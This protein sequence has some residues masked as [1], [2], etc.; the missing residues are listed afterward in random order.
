MEYFCND[1]K[2][3][4]LFTMKKLNY[5]FSLLLFTLVGGLTAWGQDDGKMY[6]AV[7]QINP[8]DGLEEG[9]D[10]VLRGTG[11]GNCSSNYLDLTADGNAGSTEILTS[12]IW[13][14]VKAGELDS[15][16]TYY[17]RNKTT[18]QY[19]RKP[20]ETLDLTYNYM[21]DN[22]PAGWGDK[23]LALTDDVAQAFL[24]WA[25]RGD[26]AVSASAG[27]RF[28]SMYAYPENPDCFIFCGVE[29]WNTLTEA[30]ENNVRWLESYA[31]NNCIANYWDVNAWY[32]Y[33][34]LQEITG[35]DK[36][37]R[38]LQQLLPQGPEGAF[39]AG[40][41]PGNVEVSAYNALTDV[42]ARVLEYMEVPTTDEE[43]EQLA[44]EIRAA[45]ENCRNS[46]IL[47]E[48]GKYYFV[49]NRARNNA[50]GRGT[51]YCN[52]GSEWNWEYV[53][54]EGR[55][56]NFSKYAVQLVAGETEGMFLVK[57]PLYNKYMEAI[58]GNSNTIMAVDSIE[59][60]EYEIGHNS[61]TYFFFRNPGI[62]QGVHA[63]E[64]GL[65]CVGWD[66]TTEASQWIFTQISD[67]KVQAIEDAARQAQLNVA[68]NNVYTTASS[69]YVS[70]R[71]YTSDATLDEAYESHGLL[72]STDQI[73][74]SPLAAGDGTGISCLLNGVTRGGSEYMHTTWNSG[75]APNHYHF[76]GAD[77]KK[78]VGAIT[79]KFSNRYDGY[80]RNSYPTQ[81]R[82]YA[83]N[84]TTTATG[85]WTWV[86]E[87]TTQLVSDTA[88]NAWVA[89]T[90]F[91]GTNYRYVRLD[92]TATGDN[93]S[94][95]PSGGQAFPYFY[96]SELGIYEAAYD[97]ANSPFESVPEEDGQALADALQKAR[98]EILSE[99]ATQTTVD[100]LQAAYD[101]F[102]ESY[103]D[104]QIAR[105]AIAEAQ[106]MLDSAVVGTKLA[107]VTQEA[108]DAL[109]Q[110]IADATEKVS[111]VMTM[112][113]LNGIVT[114]LEAAREALA[115]S[116]VMPEAGQY[117]WIISKGTGKNNAAIGAASNRDGQRLKFGAV[118]EVEGLPNTFDETTA[119]TYYEYV[120]LLEQDDEGNQYLRNV[121]TGFYMNGNTTANPTTTAEKTPVKVIY[122]KHG[123]FGVQ[124]LMNDS[125]ESGN[126]YLNNNA[127]DVTKYSLDNNSY[128]EFR[129]VDFGPEYYTYVPV[130]G[131]WHFMCLPYATVGSSNGVSYTVLGI[132]SENELVLAEASD[133]VAPGE[134]FV[135]YQEVEE[136]EEPITLDDFG[137]DLTQGLVSEGKTINGIQGILSGYTLSETGYG[138]LNGT[139]T[140]QV[141]TGAVVLGNN[142]AIATKDVIVTD[143][144]GAAVLPINGTLTGIGTG[145]DKVVIVPKDG[146][147][148]DGKIYDL[149]G[150]RVSRPGKGIYIVNGKKM[151]FK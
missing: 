116:A 9:V 120:W 150:R 41:N 69:A 32:V 34:D 118:T 43:A 38:I 141:N 78:A 122:G 137:V 151:I 94:V 140:L 30:G 103:A 145:I 66:Y 92:V 37:N 8:D 6:T 51:I 142:T 86:G 21:G 57:S 93:G 50:S 33:K 49:T 147:P 107:E 88:R 39:T 132:N 77:L 2:L 76:V 4:V 27:G 15:M 75:N 124:I 11:L 44:A 112:E 111:N 73:F 7:T 61:G 70:S 24:F 23:F 65:K 3:K 130:D 1:V 59:A 91:G 105:N 74:T 98:P 52:N 121:G 136:G 60:A 143:Q 89:S 131:G 108:Y 97:A 29:A 79:V 149:Q 117:Y 90:D 115:A 72:T 10:Y 87:M 14:F 40:T 109:R 129:T 54:D 22:I 16:P 133:G 47:P 62:S 55:E 12:S 139:D 101:K 84:D 128:Y 31:N 95:A 56:E 13:Q 102:I 134:P 96:I 148:K 146:V 125:T 68:L 28:Q 19:L 42:Y 123:A 82:V 83:S 35:V 25:G 85:G 46:L 119:Q 63:Q 138:I 81:I 99:K 5:L 64:N 135:Y 67:D 114:S 17:L 100:Q 53:T 58:N 144:E 36:L 126:I 48:M 71:V 45:Y 18:G 20:V 106:T 80:V 113:T 110:A 127:S 26:T 104:P